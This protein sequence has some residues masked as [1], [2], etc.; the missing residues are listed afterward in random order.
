M[1]Y[2][3]CKMG[4]RLHGLGFLRVAQFVSFRS[5]A[6]ALTALLLA[7]WLGPRFILWLHNRG[8]RDVPK[9]FKVGDAESKKGTPVMGGLLI[10]GTLLTACFLWCDLSNRF[11]QSLIAATLFFVAMGAYDDYKKI[12]VGHGEAGLSQFSKLA[13]QGGFG[14]ALAWLVGY[15]EHSPYADFYRTV[16]NVPFLKPALYGGSDI[17]LHWF[18]IPFVMLTMMFISN[19]VN[20]ADGL[21]GLAIVPAIIGAAVFAFFAY[22]IGTRD[23]AAYLL[24]RHIVGTTEITV[25][26]AGLLGAGF[27]FL[28]FNCYPAQVIM[29]DA[30]S[31]SLGG[32]LAT[33]A[34]LLKQEVLFLFAGAFFV[35]EGLSSFISQR[36]GHEFLGRRLISR[37]PLHHAFQHAGLSEPKVVVRAWILSLLAGL[38][39]IATVKLR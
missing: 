3:L 10:V 26:I 17:D 11:V 4:S 37:A 8:L 39:A 29:G 23:E 6:A 19:S 31:L 33:S 30:G 5:I 38:L 12:K 20:I 28:W 22:I 27:G 9:G 25:F 35:V 1:I 13:L 32:I 18:Y 16:I 34:I 15:S 14:L 2:W 36:I 21:D 7:V 24:F